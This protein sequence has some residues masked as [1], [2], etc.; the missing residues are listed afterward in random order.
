MDFDEVVRRRRMT[1]R[2]DSTPVPPAVRDRL[3]SAALRAPSAGSSQGVDLLVLESQASRQAFFQAT[4]DAAWR[5]RPA[6]SAAGILPAP[7]VVV[8]LAD[9]AAYVRRYG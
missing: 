1:R 9:P 2:F 4:T 3:L 6:G 7:L 8:P 5:A